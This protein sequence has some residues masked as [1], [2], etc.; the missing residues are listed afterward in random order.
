MRFE[1]PGEEN[2]RS[3]FVAQ[4]KSRA[5]IHV[6]FHL[7]AHA[8][9]THHKHARTQTNNHSSVSE[10]M[11]KSARTHIRTHHTAPAHARRIRLPL[12]SC[13]GDTLHEVFSEEEHDMRVLSGHSGP[14]WCVAVTPSYIVSGSAD[15]MPQSACLSLPLRVVLPCV[16]RHVLL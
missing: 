8:P 10:Y 13:H 7:H 1:V 2:I 9:Y 16:L 12:V 3:Q 11:Y 5:H 4:P 6:R 15:G 14:V